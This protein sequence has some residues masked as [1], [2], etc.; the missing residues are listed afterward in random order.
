MRSWSGAAPRARQTRCFPRLEASVEEVHVI[1]SKE[2]QKPEKSGGT[3][4]GNVVVSNDRAVAVDAFCLNQVFDCPEKR[5]ESLRPGVDQT[6]TENIE[7][8][9]ARDVTIGIIFRRPHV[10]QY[11]FRIR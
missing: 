4:S 10:H 1:V 2:F 3:H 7:A 8:P 11:K 5:F 6:D 9:G